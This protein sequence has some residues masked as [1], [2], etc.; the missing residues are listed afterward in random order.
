MPCQ[1][2]A[3]LSLE[4]L[5]SPKELMACLPASP[6][7]LA[8]VQQAQQRVIDILNG[9]SS[10]VLLIVGPC[11]IHDTTAARDF[12]KKL[13]SLADRVGDRCELIMRAY[14]E[15]PRTALGWKGLLYDPKLDGS[16]DILVGLQQSRQLLL[17]LADM[18]VP[19]ATEFLDLS[20]PHYLGDLITW[21]SVGSRTTESQPHRLMVSATRI[22]T[23]F[24]NGTDGDLSIAINALLV[25][26][27]PHTFLG[28]NSD[29]RIN[30]IRSNGNAHCH[31]VLRGGGGRPNFDNASVEQAG[32]LLT[33]EGL[34][35]RLIIDC[36]HDNS[37]KD[38]SRQSIAFHS[39][40][41][42]LLNDSQQVC[43]M[44]LESNLKGGRQPLSAKA[45]VCSQQSV[46][47]ACLGWEETE[48]LILE[49]YAA[50]KASRS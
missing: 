31:I 6:Q 33:Q 14:F 3:T 38:P 18:E 24:K 44:I 10:R 34:Q 7:Q 19:A 41:Q 29:G 49:G 39:A 9:Q 26:N 45:T 12:A 47:D 23:G 22:P 43:G 8:F 48:Q 25:A 28:P 16:N 2:E 4:S 46:T 40:I 30:I 36:S 35:Q 15:K 5:P 17:D 1:V 37:G 20:A 50:L 21:A 11:S 27:T 32:R 42:Q 13:R